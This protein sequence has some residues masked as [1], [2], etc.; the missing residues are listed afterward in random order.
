[1][2]DYNWK[3]LKEYLKG[4]IDAVELYDSPEKI[5]DFANK[6]YKTHWSFAFCKPTNSSLKESWRCSAAV[7]MIEAEKRK[8]SESN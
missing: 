7:E 2:S 6:I 4:L 1:M 3:R 5:T 8:E